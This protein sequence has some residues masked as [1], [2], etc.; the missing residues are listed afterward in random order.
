MRSIDDCIDIP[1][2]NP[3][4]HGSAVAKL[5]KLNGDM[6]PA[7]RTALGGI[8][9]SLSALLSLGACEDDQTQASATQDAGGAGESSTVDR[10]PPVEDT[11]ADICSSLSLP[12]TATPVPVEY[13]DAGTPVGEG[14]TIVPGIY[15]AVRYVTGNVLIPNSPFQL[16]WRFTETEL[17]E[18]L[19]FGPVTKGETLRSI[20]TWKTEGNSLELAPSC[21]TPSP[22][23]QTYTAK[24]NTLEIFCAECRLHLTLERQP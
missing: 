9:L 5:A 1:S 10:R 19:L 22:P 24:G 2:R 13:T 11:G 14:G 20:D 6:A 12:N 15:H 4:D 7:L 3:N 8:L 21:D 17:E 18:V 23:A 16:T